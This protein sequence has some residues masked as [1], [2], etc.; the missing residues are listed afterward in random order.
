MKEH[1]KNR[2][3]TSR[4][5]NSKF[6]FNFPTAGVVMG[7]YYFIPA[8]FSNG[9]IGAGGV[10]NEASVTSF[11]GARPDRPNAW[12]DPNLTYTRVPERI[13]EVGWYRR[14]TPMTI[15]EIVGAILDFYLYAK[16]ALGGTGAD[17]SWVAGPPT[18]PS[19]VQGLTCFLYNSIFANFPSELYTSVPLLDTVVSAVSGLIA[20][21][22]KSLG[23]DAN[24]P[25]ATGVDAS[26]QWQSFISIYVGPA[27]TQAVGSACYQAA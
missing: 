17:Q 20:P 22:Y 6:Y 14:A 27:K 19:N 13:P 23:C 11:Y 15:A 5:A 21:G 18:V 10:A 8:F 7:A 4:A 26:R 16:P 2:Y 1:F 24:L 9:T 3:A 25:K 12:D